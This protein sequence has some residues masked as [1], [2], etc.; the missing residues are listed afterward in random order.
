M[1][2][3]ILVRYMTNGAYENIICNIN[4][5][6]VGAVSPYRNY[7]STM[8]L[9]PFKDL[10]WHK[11]KRYRHLILILLLLRGLVATKPNTFVSVP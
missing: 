6:G 8:L 3:T 7:F 11:R 10:E 5:V 4:A 2:T 1:S 9:R